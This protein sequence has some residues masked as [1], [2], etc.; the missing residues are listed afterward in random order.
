MRGG[1]HDAGHCSLLADGIAHLGSGTDVVEDVHVD[2]VGGKD[3]RCDARELAA[4]VAAVVGDTDL[5]V[6]SLDVLE[7]VVGESLRGHS[8]RVFVHAVGAY[9]HDAPEASGTEL[10]VL[11][12][13]ILEPGRV[14]VAELDDT[15]FGLRIEISVQPALGHF[16]IIFH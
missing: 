4:V 15:A 9:A 2:A 6:V 1:D 16:F 3:V 12:E 13:C 14:V 7:D 5:E 10:E 8:D 11:V